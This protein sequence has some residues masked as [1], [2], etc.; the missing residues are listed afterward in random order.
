MTLNKTA[1]YFTSTPSGA[2]IYLDNSLIGITPITKTQLLPGTHT[3]KLVLRE[4]DD[5]INTVNVVEGSTTTIS[6]ELSIKGSTQNPAPTYTTTPTL[7]STPMD[8]L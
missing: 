4:Y 1:I 3:I 7:T 2:S 6:A 5:W 8:S